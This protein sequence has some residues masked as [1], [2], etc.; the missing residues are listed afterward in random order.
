MSTSEDSRAVKTKRHVARNKG[1]YGLAIGGA[2]ILEL[3]NVAGAL[4]PLLCSFPFVPDKAMCL[5]AFQATRDA[6]KAAMELEKSS[7]AGADITLDSV[8]L[9]QDNVAPIPTI[10][11]TVE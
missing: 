5:A 7:P 4:G 2:C 9:D 1:K 3:L 11:T 8:R 10:T 6:S